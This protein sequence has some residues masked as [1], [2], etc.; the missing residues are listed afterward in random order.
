MAKYTTKQRQALLSYLSDHA[1]ERL[2]AGQISAAIDDAGISLSAVYRNLSALEAEG[3]V[4]RY[5][6]AGSRDVF[7]QYI[8]APGCLG[9]LHLS[10]T[11]CG[12]TF[13][14]NTAQASMLIS[15]VEQAEDFSVDKS[16]T[17]L[18]GVCKNCK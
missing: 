8:A 4:K 10:C 15:Q 16:D 1:D 5:S 12:K 18:Y 6:K 17:V 7:F 13:H 3:K 11:R 9:N 14:M 2:S